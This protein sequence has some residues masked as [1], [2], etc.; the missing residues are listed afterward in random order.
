MHTPLRL[1]VDNDPLTNVYIN[2]SIK[3]EE[4]YL[5]MGTGKIYLFY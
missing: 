4:G 5:D 1:I 3:T 2:T